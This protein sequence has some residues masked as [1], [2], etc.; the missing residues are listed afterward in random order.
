[1]ESRFF[2]LTVRLVQKLAWSFLLPVP[3]VRKSDLVFFTYGCSSVSKRNSIVSKKDPRVC[4]P[5]FPNRGWRLPA[6]QRLT[7]GKKEVKLRQTEVNLRLKW[8]RGACSPDYSQ[9]QKHVIQLNNSQEL[10]SPNMSSQLQL[11]NSLELIVTSIGRCQ[12]DDFRITPPPPPGFVW[13][14]PQFSGG[15]ISTKNCL[16]IL[17]II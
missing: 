5:W 14:V 8:G 13:G 7:W 11:E 1:M 3:L 15:E 9:G 6:Q 12:L 17:I 4:K 2:L 16:R 10:I